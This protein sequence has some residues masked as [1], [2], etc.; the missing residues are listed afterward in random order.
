MEHIQKV[1][2]DNRS[3]YWLDPLI[4][5]DLNN[6]VES[7]FDFPITSIAFVFCCFEKIEMYWILDSP[8]RSHVQTEDFLSI[9]FKGFRG[10][11]HIVDEFTL[12]DLQFMNPSDWISLLNLFMKDEKK[13]EPIVAYLKR[14]IICY[15]LENAKMD[16]ENT[17]VLK[18]GPI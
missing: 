2:I 10:A 7:Q 11:N 14:L 9:P 8:V 15:I 3:I 13:C 18:K 12:A 16:V 1:V 4:S 5:F 17:S 6:D